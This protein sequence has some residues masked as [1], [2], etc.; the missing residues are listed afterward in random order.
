[1][2]GVRGWDIEGV[3]GLRNVRGI[4]GVSPL[5]PRSWERRKLSRQ[6]LM[7]SPGRKRSYS[8]V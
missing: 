1:M 7:R 8:A 4:P 5:Q 3:E 2:R 6:G